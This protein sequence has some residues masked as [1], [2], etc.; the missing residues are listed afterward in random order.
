MYLHRFFESLITTR[1]SKSCWLHHFCYARS[2]RDFGWPLFVTSDF[3][4]KA[5]NRKLQ[6]QI[7]DQ[8]G[9]GGC[10]C[11]M[12]G[13]GRRCWQIGIEVLLA[14]LQCRS[15]PKSSSEELIPCINCVYK[16]CWQIWRAS[17]DYLLTRWRTQL[18]RCRRISA[19]RIDT[20]MLFNMWWPQMW[21]AD[22]SD[23]FLLFD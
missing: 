3:Q 15:F 23:L 22:A 5:D 12:F 9:K 17:Q 14:D 16:A 10:S 18:Q 1:Q 20:K 21:V 8:Q 6:H 19:S 7:Q 11:V 13:G 2:N 4:V